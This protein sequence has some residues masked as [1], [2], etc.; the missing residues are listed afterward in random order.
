MNFAQ[1]QGDD[2]WLYVVEH[3][4]E[5]NKVKIHTIQ[6]PAQKITQHRFDSGWKTVAAP[7]NTFTPSPPKVGS[8][9]QWHQD[10]ELRTGRIASVGALLQVD[11]ENQ[12]RT[13][14]GVANR[15]L[16]F[17]VLTP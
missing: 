15:P 5:L 6:N 12:L 14:I 7:P 8:R 16:Q 10:G 1:E 4:R 17:E 11:V 3:A 13:R 2:F 9:I